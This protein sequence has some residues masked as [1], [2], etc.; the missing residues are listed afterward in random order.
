MN[1][2]TAVHPN[3]VWRDRADFIVAA[4]ISTDSTGDEWEQLWAKQLNES[5]FELCCIPFFAY[6]LA[7]GDEV[8]CGTHRGRDYVVRQITRPSG[9][10]TFRVWLGD[11]PTQDERSTVV[12]QIGTVASEV[13]WSSTNLMAVDAADKKT[14]ESVGSMLSKYAAKGWLEFETGRTA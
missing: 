9:R 5:R 10:F 1:V 3:P 8:E 6:D 12:E 13:E 4:D 7:L 11:T 2:Y 14:A